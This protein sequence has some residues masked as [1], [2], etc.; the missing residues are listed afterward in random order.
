MVSP[1]RYPLEHFPQL[2]LRTGLRV[3]DMMMLKALQEIYET[4][5]CRFIDSWWYTRLRVKNAFFIKLHPNNI[6][7][8]N[9]IVIPEAYDCVLTVKITGN[10][11]YSGPMREHSFSTE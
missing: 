10:R 5:L 4:E 1:L 9:G 6:I 8:D 2:W 11:Y 7:R 3:S